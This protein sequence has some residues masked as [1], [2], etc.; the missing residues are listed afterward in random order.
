M[1]QVVAKYL[2][3]INSGGSNAATGKKSNLF[4]EPVK[5]FT[6][7]SLHKIPNIINKKQVL[8]KLPNSLYGPDNSPEICLIV[9]DAVN[10]KKNRD[11]EQTIRKYDKIIEAQKLKD[12]IKM[13]L[14]IKQIKLEFR[15]FEIKRKLSTSY[16]LFLAD[17]GL[18][19]ILFSGSH[20]GREFQRR[21][22]MP[23]EI[24]LE[25]C[26]DNLKQTID[27]ILSSTTIRLHGKGPIIDVHAFNS[28]NT[29]QEAMA[30]ISAIREQL[31]KCLPGGL[32][33]IKCIYLKA[34]DESV[35]LP[36]YV[37]NPLVTKTT[38]EKEPAPTAAEELKI[39]NNMTKAKKLRKKK[40][41]SK[42]VKRI[43]AKKEKSSKKKAATATAKK[44]NIERNL[45]KS[46]AKESAKPAANGAKPAKAAP[47]KADPKPKAAKE[48]TTKQKPAAKQQKP[49]KPSILAAKS[50]SKVVKPKAKANAELAKTK[51]KINLVK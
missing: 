8:C 46:A 5:I 31:E 12:V 15:P 11:F 14:P 33:N 48:T 43:A 20:L 38:E 40:K 29:V 28:N 42:R 16:N 50:Q 39:K 19:D 18:H 24:D 30:N 47:K 17:K 32:D 9:K 13:I 51:K 34:T 21:N 26:E 37:S 49:A 23:I 2:E 44:A 7:I 35:S 45:V 4:E 41:D 27:E 22:K 1:E 25:K 36:I 10:E 6:Q 3:H